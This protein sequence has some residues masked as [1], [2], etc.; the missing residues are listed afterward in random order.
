MKT[1]EPDKPSLPLLDLET[2]DTLRQLGRRRG[3]DLLGQLFGL[4]SDQGP[5]SFA[6]L[7]RA[8]L[9]G[10]AETVRE[11]AHSLKGSYRSLGTPRLAKRCEALEERGRGGG[12][13]AGLSS[14]L[15]ELERDFV[16]TRE[17]LELFL[18]GETPEPSG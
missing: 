5:E 1:E 16:Q 18:A 17:A 11:V 4:F 15:D 13:L 14:A 2:L 9:E 10:D 8:A 6:K 7:R 3:R 12:D